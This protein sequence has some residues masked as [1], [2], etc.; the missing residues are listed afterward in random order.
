VERGWSVERGWQARLLLLADDDQ[1]EELAG[2]PALSQ[3]SNT[4][5]PV[6]DCGEELAGAPVLSLPSR[7]CRGAWRRKGCGGGVRPGAAAALRR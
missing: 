3:H 1:A 4:G 7:G 6:L 5:T 2:A